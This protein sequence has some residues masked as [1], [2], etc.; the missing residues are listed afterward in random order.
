[1]PVAIARAIARL[2]PA[3]TR[4][5]AFSDGDITQLANL[6]HQLPGLTTT[7]ASTR[8]RTEFALNLPAALADVRQ[9]ELGAAY[10]PEGARGALVP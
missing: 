4:Q 5:R 7:P 3:I 2:F 8:H 9:G 10:A 1:M 6:C